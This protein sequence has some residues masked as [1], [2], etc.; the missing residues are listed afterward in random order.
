[1]LKNNLKSAFRDFQK[2]RIFS[3]IN[4]LG[5]TVG[6]TATML[7]GLYVNYEHSFDKFHV[8]AENIHRFTREF[9]GSDGTLAMHFSNIAPPFGPLLKE[10]F[11]K[12]IKTLGRFMTTEAS[13]RSES[14]VF[15]E[16]NFAFADPE[17]FDVLSFYT[18]EGVSRDALIQP[19]AIAISASTAAKYFGNNNPIGQTLTY[20]DDRNFLVMGVFKDFPA[21][22][23][24]RI[25][26]LT[27]M[28]IVEEFLADEGGMTRAW[29]N[30]I[31]QTMFRLNDGIQLAEIEGRLESFMISHLGKDA[32][33]RNE[34]H[35]QKLT[36]VHLRSNLSD[37]TGKNGDLTEVRIFTLLAVLILT[38][39]AANYVNLSTGRLMSRA[40][41]VGVRK[42]LGANRLSLITQFLTE[43]VLMVV[44]SVALASLATVV[45]IPV[46]NQL[47]GLALE[48]TMAEDWNLVI[49]LLIAALFMGLVAGIYPSLYLSSVRPVKALKKST[50]DSQRHGSGLRRILV[51][52]QFAISAA[53]I[54]ASVVVYQQLNYLNNKPL[55]YDKEEI[56]VLTLSNEANTQYEALK[57]ELLTISGVVSVGGS[58]RVPS[59]ELLD[60]NRGFVERNG[61][62]TALNS[63]IVIKK[64]TVD[65]DFISTYKMNLQAGRNF[66]SNRTGDSRTFILNE[67]SVEVIGWNNAEEAIGQPMIY[68]NVRGTVIGVLEDFHFESLQ[69]EIA[70]VIL[71]NN[72]DRARHLSVKME[73]ENMN[74]AL[75][76]LK[77]VYDGFSPNDPMDYVFLDE[78]F[79]RLYESETRSSRL[80]MMFSSMAIFL[81]CLG[82]FGL[83]LF[84]VSQR[85]KEV[86][87]RKVLGASANQIMGILSKEFIILIIV[88][89]I[90]AFPVAWY[91]MGDWLDGYA[92]RIGLS[93]VPFVGAAVI[94]GGIALITIGM[95]T[96]KA[97]VSNPS[98]RLRDE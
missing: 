52:F 69:K 58:S 77:K 5:L 1:M 78:G 62:M 26:M 74:A 60:S 43:S 53:L 93:W 31:L 96:F 55:G 4:T 18:I 29:D 89:M 57:N 25:D 80:L 24:I 54:V 19:N 79:R 87:I 50:A 82:L 56:I 27:D 66:D 47:T 13:I 98:D 2:H 44:I 88:S 72:S 41:N 22:S 16:K 59:G 28:T 76:A 84:S 90:L 73:T 75:P 32:P 7:I 86:T 85:A 46:L 70:P 30:N 20:N 39:A 97:A 42:I 92:Y 8:D 49:W 63:E 95:Q 37:E 23:S 17:I 11:A 91:F 51:V 40:K 81:A 94:A 14:Q 71:M 3:V 65:A 61:E 34:L 45:L 12:E 15:I 68:D 21:N 38:I 10:E 83:A 35:I 64:L 48:I 9:K 67:R 33:D 36:D 6:L